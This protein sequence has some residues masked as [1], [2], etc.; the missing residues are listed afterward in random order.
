MACAMSATGRTSNS[1]TKQAGRGSHFPRPFF[2]LPKAQCTYKP[3]CG[4]NHTPLPARTHSVAHSCTPD[5][6]AEIQK[7]YCRRSLVV[8]RQYPLAA[9]FAIPLRTLARIIASSSWLN[10][11]L[12]LYTQIIQKSRPHLP[13][14]CS[15]NTSGYRI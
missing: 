12:N 11:S 4:S 3:S 5:S 2:M 14:Y 9:A 15:N 6:G 8:C 1:P 13:L 10:I 7:G